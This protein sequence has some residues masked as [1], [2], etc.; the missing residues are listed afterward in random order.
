[1]YRLIIIALVVF[2]V[3]VTALDFFDDF[4]SYNVGADP[5]DGPDWERK[6]AG[7]NLLVINDGGDKVVNSV[8]GSY[9]KITY[10]CLGGNICTDAAIEMDFEYFGSG[11]GSAAIWCRIDLANDDGYS[12][13]LFFN[14]S[15]ETHVWINYV[16]GEN[17]TTLY[18]AEITHVNP[19]TW[20]K[21][22]VT[23]TGTNPVNIK[24]YVN[25]GLVADYNDT[26]YLCSTGYQGIYCDYD[27]I[28]INYHIDDY[29]VDDLTTGIK[30]ASLGEIKAIYK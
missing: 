13:G 29:N 24:V 22:G 11:E 9:D 18:V 23:V 25:D 19:D 10:S 14:D 1:M 28:G 3:P 2:S 17:Y 6:T 4:E 26:T 8:F 7:G 20:T 30:S 21:L 15:D 12:A 27:T 16:F 5:A